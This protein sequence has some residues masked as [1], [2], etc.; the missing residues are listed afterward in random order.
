MIHM[1][2]V[3]SLM[4]YL[5]NKQ[6]VQTNNLEFAHIWIQLDPDITANQLLIFLALSHYLDRGNIAINQSM[7]NQ[8]IFAIGFDQPILLEETLGNSTLVGKIGE[9]KPFIIHENLLYSHKNFI[10][11]KQLAEWLITKS[12]LPI[13]IENSLLKKIEQTI[14]YDDNDLQKQALYKSFYNSLLFITGGPG[15][16]KTFTI[17]EIISA[18]RSVFGE[19]YSIKIA[20]PTG[21]A[22]QRINESLID[23]EVAFKAMTIHQLLGFKDVLKGYK[24]S[25]KNPVPAD[26]IIVDE[27]SMIDLNIWIALINAVSKNTRL[28]V[29]GDAFQLASVEAGS[30]FSD[31]CAAPIAS[32]DK[33]LFQNSITKL[34]KRHRFSDKSGIK[35]FADSIN[36]MDS[37]CALSILEDSTIND[38][39]W[40]LPNQENI[41]HALS[42]YAIKPAIDHPS[43]LMNEY[44]ILSVL[45]NGKYGCNQFNSIIESKLKK[46]LKVAQSNKWYKNRI[47]MA[48][49]ND[50]RL[51]IQNGE[52]GV[53]NERTK[54]VIFEGE[55]N[56]LINELSEFEPGYCITV[57]KSQGSEYDHVAIILPDHES[58]ILSKE[59]LYTAVTRARKSVLI[60]GSKKILTYCINNKIKRESGLVKQLKVTMS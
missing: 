18:H 35:R 17:R 3:R 5:E 41:A 10:Q 46:K 33:A 11:E 58:P 7:V 39:T 45:R 14:F 47:I 49:K 56:V 22:A 23:E 24:Y 36:D 57:H 51:D 28:V 59:L 29:V 44:R 52:I 53:Y 6:L 15:T 20:A 40:V 12:K 31:I 48:T 21:K 50:Y 55:K 19:S 34:E 2:T 43:S 32:N 26:L 13:E 9:F 38:V 60:I 27:A 4:S 16:G 37:K 8:F 42:K 1:E 25:I 30:V 54:S